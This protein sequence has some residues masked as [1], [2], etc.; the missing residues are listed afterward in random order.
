MTIRSKSRGFFE[1]KFVVITG[2]S[3]GIGLA[4]A[5]LVFKLGAHVCI[6]ARNPHALAR[7]GAVIEGARVR[8]D[9]KIETIACDCTNIWALK[10]LLEDLVARWGPPDCLINCVGYA[11]PGYVQ[12]L[13]ID[14]FRAHMEV[15]YYGQLAP[16]LLLLPHLLRAGRGHVANI[17]SLLGF[18]G[19]MGYSAYCPSKFA[20][21]GL[22]DALRNELKPYGLS[23][24]IVYPPDV[25]TPGYSQE[26]RNKPPECK[27]LSKRARVMTAEA[28]AKAIVDG[29]ARK[30]FEIVPGEAAFVWRM[31]RHFPWLVRR[32]IDRDYLK[33]RRTLASQAYSPRAEH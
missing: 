24:S 18:M 1:A 33:A 4:I 16:L 14:D 29:I 10:P 28:V 3:S 6:V 31:Y 32:A 21:A 5:E 12:E 27:E 15:N 22:T 8:A 20:I 9:Q 25:E 19:S 17:S 23:F 30:R 2:G 26:N 7:A 13:D 11:R